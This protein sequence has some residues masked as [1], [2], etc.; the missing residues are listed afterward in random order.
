MLSST[1]FCYF[2]LSYPLFR[3]S[4][5][6]APLFWERM[7]LLPTKTELMSPECFT[8][9]SKATPFWGIY[10]NKI[11]ILNILNISHYFFPT[12]LKYPLKEP[13]CKAETSVEK[14]NPF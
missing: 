8:A 4:K 6:T 11:N 12:G 2:L 5:G 13:F 9:A 10:L 3:D 1:Y 7:A 14:V